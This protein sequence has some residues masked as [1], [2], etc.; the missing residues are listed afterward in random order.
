MNCGSTTITLTRKAPISGYFRL[1]QKGCVDKR[2]YYVVEKHL[3]FYP[4]LPPY[5]LP[6][7][8]TPDDDPNTTS[9]EGGTNPDTGDEPSTP[10]DDPNATSDEGGTNPDTGDE[11]STPNDDPNTTSDEG[12]TNPDTGDEPS[13]EPLSSDELGEPPTGPLPN[14]LGND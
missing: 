11:P 1:S 6:P 13:E 10:N 7:S 2:C 12:G 9:D 3:G 14:P 5:L 8:S 4:A